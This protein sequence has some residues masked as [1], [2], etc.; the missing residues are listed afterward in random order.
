M[1]RGIP[2]RGQVLQRHQRL[3]E[4]GH[5]FLIGGALHGPAN[6]HE[7]QGLPLSIQATPQP[8][9]MVSTT[10]DTAS[11]S[12]V[13][14]TP[15]EGC[16]QRLRGRQAAITTSATPHQRWSPHTLFSA[17]REVLLARREG[18]GVADARITAD[19]ALWSLTLTM[20]AGEGTARGMGC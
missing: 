11:H 18:V 20:P 1:V 3:L 15:G 4:T 16:E 9:R 12:S 5:G 17:V 8:C 2:L 19:T 13:W 6:V 14:Y 7:M 10:R